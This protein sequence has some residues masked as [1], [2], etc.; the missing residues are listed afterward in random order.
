MPFDLAYL[1]QHKAMVGIVGGA[2]IIGI[3]IIARAQSGGS[4]CAAVS[5]GLDPNA[6]SLYEQQAQ[7]GAAQQNTA[8]QENYGLAL[9][10]IQADAQSH[11]TDTAAGVSLAGI[12]AQSDVQSKQIAEQLDQS[13]NNLVAQQSAIEAQLAGLESNNATTSDVA[14]IA[15]TENVDIANLTSETQLGISNNQSQVAIAQTQAS[16]DV[17]LGAQGTAVKTT[18]IGSAGGILGAIGG[19]LGGL[20]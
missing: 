2:A 13:N 20:L 3:V 18:A 7:I 12:A 5:S 19:F 17:A 1:K 14:R 4:F 9:A 16:R 6:V 15:A 8:S 11:Q 10:Q